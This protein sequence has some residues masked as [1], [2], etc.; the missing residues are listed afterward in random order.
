LLFAQVRWICETQSGWIPQ[1][2]LGSGDAIAQLIRDSLL[3][4]PPFYLIYRARLSKG[5]KIRVLSVF[6]ASAI[7]TIVSLTHAYYICTGG[8]LEEDMAALVEVRCQCSY[9]P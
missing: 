7:T 4:F 5:Q 3:I 6:S 2:D 9:I 1:C 8:G